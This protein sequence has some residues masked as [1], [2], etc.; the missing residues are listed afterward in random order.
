MKVGQYL[1]DQGYK[2][3]AQSPRPESFLFEE[4]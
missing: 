2:P 1:W 4:P 3:S